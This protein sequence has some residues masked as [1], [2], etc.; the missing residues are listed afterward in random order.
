MQLE[1]D[2]DREQCE[3]MD[4]VVERKKTAAT[5]AGSAGPRARPMWGSRRVHDENLGSEV[6]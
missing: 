2:E 5:V 4:I 1:D 6:E 3:L